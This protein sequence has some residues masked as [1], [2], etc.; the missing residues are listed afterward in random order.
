[1]QSA[2]N[3]L[4]DVGGRHKEKLTV[5][6]EQMH[7]MLFSA[8]TE[9]KI[10]PGTKLPEEDL[11]QAFGVSRT[12]IRELLQRL[13]HYGIVKLPPHRSAIVAKPSEAE[14]RQVFQARRLLETG[15]IPQVLKQISDDDEKSLQILLNMEREAVRTGNRSKAITYSGEFHIRLCQ[16]IDNETLL[17]MLRVLVSRT[18]LIL[19]VFPSSGVS[20]CD[21]ANHANLMKEIVTRDREAAANALNNDLLA[22]ERSLSF[23]QGDGDAPNFKEILS[24]YGACID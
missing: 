22:A 20:S 23:V 13:S 18:S 9:H 16:I 5:T 21:C 6:S 24:D 3:P 12:R 2:D 7:Q 17:G 1:M 11:A 19:A 8:I 4:I 10:L 15:M 14:A